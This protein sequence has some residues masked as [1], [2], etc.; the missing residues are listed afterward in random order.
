[1][2]IQININININ[3]HRKKNTNL[4]KKLCLLCIS[5]LQIRQKHSVY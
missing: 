5:I 1:M 3:S 2:N 4:R